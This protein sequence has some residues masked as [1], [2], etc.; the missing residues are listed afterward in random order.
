M[1][2]HMC[3]FE[4]FWGFLTAGRTLYSLFKV[5]CMLSETHCL[6]VWSSDHSKTVCLKTLVVGCIM[7]IQLNIR[8]GTFYNAFSTG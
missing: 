8:N 4:V 6:C 7:A 2:M 1:C 3:I 5:N